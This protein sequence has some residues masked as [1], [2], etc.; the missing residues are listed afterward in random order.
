MDVQLYRKY[1]HQFVRDSIK[2]SNGTVNSI[3]EELD[4]IQVGGLLSR[5]KT[6][7][8]RALKDAQKAFDEHRHWPLQIILS[9]LGVEAPE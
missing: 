4:I 8:K 1:L 6:E 5:H 2:R 3:R 7:K 9:H